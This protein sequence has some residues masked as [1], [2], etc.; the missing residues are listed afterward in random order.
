MERLQMAGIAAGVVKTGAEVIAEDP[1][2]KHRDYLK[3][4]NHPAMDPSL[5]PGTPGKLSLTPSQMTPAPCFGE[6]TEYVC[7]EILKM[8]DGEFMKLL[9][10]GVFD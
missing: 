4:L 2:M 8:P 6:H 1:Q 3:M 9:S 10:S 7:R 5:H